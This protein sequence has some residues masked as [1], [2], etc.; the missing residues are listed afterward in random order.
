[1]NKF[2]AKI[3]F[4]SLCILMLSSCAHVE[5]KREIAE[6]RGTEIGNPLA[7]DIRVIASR[8]NERNEPEY[9]KDLEQFNTS[10][11]SM[12]KKCA[13]NE[14]SSPTKMAS[15][16][17]DLVQKMGKVSSNFDTDDYNSVIYAFAN[18]ISEMHL[19]ETAGGER[20]NA[21]GKKYISN[22]CNLIK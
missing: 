4:L 6:E 10:L 11:V 19:A 21:L 8:A 22:F 17:S 5:P 7:N 12:R 18:S 20:G 16:I 15:D 9:Q 2:T 1:M 14:N 13:N 3:S